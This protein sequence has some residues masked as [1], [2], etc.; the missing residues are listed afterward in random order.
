M[1]CLLLFIFVLLLTGAALAQARPSD[2]PPRPAPSGVTTP[3]A[4][5]ANP[6]ATTPYLATTRKSDPATTA[7]RKSPLA[8]VIDTILNLALVLV[9]AYLAM[10]GVKRYMAGTLRLPGLPVRPQTRLLQVVETLPL[11]QGR[12]IYLVRAGDR[13][14][15]IGAGGQQLSLLGEVTGD[16]AVEAAR[17]AL[18]EVTPPATFDATLARLLPTS[19]PPEGTAAPGR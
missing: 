17:A 7:P 15:L 4:D 6:E 18:D 8:V 1:R 16:A 10:L 11:A 5:P 3:A 12:S 9:L 14:Y 13:S 2:L 19:V